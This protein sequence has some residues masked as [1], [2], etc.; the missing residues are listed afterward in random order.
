VSNSPPLC[1]A[2]TRGSV[3]EITLLPAREGRPVVLSSLLLE[4]LGAHA[5]AA[6]NDGA[7]RAG[8]IT[9]T[10]RAFC[11]G[12]D[13]REMQGLDAAGAETFAKGGQAVFQRIEQSRLV[14]IAA[15]N[16]HCLGGG[17]E[18][19][20]ACDIR[21]C[22]EKARLGQPEVNLGTVPGFG[23]TQRLSR[24]VGRG[25]AAQMILTG[26]V[27]GA[28]QALAAGLVTEVTPTDGLLERARQLAG[29]IAAKGPTAIRLAKQAIYQGAELD[30]SD[31][32]DMEAQ[33]FGECF[34]TG[35]AAEGLAAFLEKRAPHWPGRP[36]E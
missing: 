18:M 5:L 10:E 26:E 7:I 21:I 22:H 20:L 35:E 23:G 12:A 8:I 32:L 6:E 31:A 3:V 17:C 2:E 30:L 29:A 16:G 19:A 11:A 27:I 34:G 25:R 13:I 14:W 33:L 36:A 28:E 1:K 24:I 4:Q 15:I 9:G